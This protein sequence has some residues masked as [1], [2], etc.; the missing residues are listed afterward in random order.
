MWMDI[1]EIFQNVITFTIYA[2]FLYILVALLKFYLNLRNYIREEAVQTRQDT[3]DQVAQ[4]LR[5]RLGNLVILH[6]TEEDLLIRLATIQNNVTSP[7]SI[8]RLY[9]HYFQDG[10]I[11]RGLNQSDA[12]SENDMVIRRDGTAP[13]A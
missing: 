11:E 10:H 7:P 8:L 3:Q 13:A 9:M 1:L 2:Q 5:Q 12:E 6:G 4:H